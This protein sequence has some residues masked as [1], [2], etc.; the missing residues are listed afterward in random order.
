MRGEEGIDFVDLMSSAARWSISERKN[1]GTD[2]FDTRL[3]MK[4]VDTVDSPTG[5][6][7]GIFVLS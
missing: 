1:A 3:K 6:S 2:D 4:K 5:H 7:R